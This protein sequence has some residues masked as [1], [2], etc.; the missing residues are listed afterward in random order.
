MLHDT[1]LSKLRIHKIHKIH[2]LKRYTIRHPTLISVNT[3]LVKCCTD[4]CLLPGKTLCLLTRM[5][6]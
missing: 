1:N 5:L 6:N 4:K 3:L 2:L